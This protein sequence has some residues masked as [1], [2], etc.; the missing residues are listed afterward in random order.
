MTLWYPPASADRP[1]AV[2][3]W[4]ALTRCTTAAGEPRY[5][6]DPAE[7]ILQSSGNRIEITGV[8]N[9]LPAIEDHDDA[10]V[11]LTVM[12]NPGLDVDGTDFYRTEGD[13]AYKS[14]VK[15]R[16]R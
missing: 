7:G 5:C 1:G 3:R 10:A 14:P 8:Q 15:D 6:R 4:P 13:A 12:V 16:R 11:F 9:T 2:S